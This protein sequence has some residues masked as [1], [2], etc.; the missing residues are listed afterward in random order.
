M[1]IQRLTNNYVS[2]APLAHKTE[3]DLL[4]PTDSEE[5]QR[6]GFVEMVGPG[7]PD[8]KGQLIPTIVEPGKLVYMM[9]HGQE[10]IV[11][12]LM[13]KPEDTVLA[14]EYDLLGMA[15]PDY[16]DGKIVGVKNF[17]PLGSWCLIEKIEATDHNFEDILLP[18]SYIVPTNTARVLRTGLGWM[19][20]DRTTVPLQVK[21]GDIV[22]YKPYNT[23]D[24]KLH[25]LGIPGNLYLVDHQDIFGIVSLDENK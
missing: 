9:L 13:R 16:V 14:S 1:K 6:W 3:F 4:L 15:D 10:S 20:M 24:I 2:I 12:P 17:Q 8:S 21:D 5:T 23:L 11:D 18:Q 7:V 19:T 22:L 25:L